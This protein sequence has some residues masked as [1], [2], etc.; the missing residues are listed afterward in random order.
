MEESTQLTAIEHGL[1]SSVRSTSPESSGIAETS[2]PLPMR[3]SVTLK[4]VGSK[5]PVL[6]WARV[7]AARAPKEATVRDLMFAVR[8]RWTDRDNHV[9]EHVAFLDALVCWIAPRMATGQ[10]E[11]GPVRPKVM[12]HGHGDVNNPVHHSIGVARWR[13]SKSISFPGRKWLDM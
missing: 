10:I 11:Q 12:V 8:S 4:L 5:V 9:E 7:P 13:E 1:G 3:A 2:T 6:A